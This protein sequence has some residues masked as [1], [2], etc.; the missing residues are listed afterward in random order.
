MDP[1][2]PLLLVDVDGVL[3]PYA[4]DVCPEGYREYHFFPDQEPVRLAQVHGE[5]LLGLAEAFDLVWAT[6]WGEMAHRHISPVLGLPKFPAIAFPPVPFA[7]LEKLP[8][9]D[10]FVRARPLAWIDDVISEEAQHWAAQRGSPTLIVKV[11]P[12][13]GLTIDIVTRLEEWA[14]TSRGKVTG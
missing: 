13:I 5:W 8:A 10:A 2:K 3:N 1:R 6:G 11:D 14:T 4:A 9:I 7:P 12:A